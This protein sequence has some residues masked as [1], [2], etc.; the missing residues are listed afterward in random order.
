MRAVFFFL[1]GQF[2]QW[3][4]RRVCIERR[5]T[6][7]ESGR[8]QRKSASPTSVAS[9]SS[10]LHLP[11]RSKLSSSSTFRRGVAGKAAG[12][13]FAKRS[14]PS[15]APSGQGAATR[16]SASSDD[17]P[18]VGNCKNQRPTKRPRYLEGG[19]ADTSE[20]E[21]AAAVV[22]PAAFAP[23]AALVKVGDDGG[24][25]RL[26][27]GWDV[28]SDMDV[29]ALLGMLYD[30]KAFGPILKGVAL[31]WC[32]VRVLKGCLPPGKVVPDAA[33]EA[34][35]NTV[36]LEGSK[37]ISRAAQEAGCT[38]EVLWVRVTLPAEKREL[39]AAVV[40]R[41]CTLVI[42]LFYRLLESLRVVSSAS[43]VLLPTLPVLSH[44]TLVAAELVEQPPR[45]PLARLAAALPHATLDPSDKAITLPEGASWP[46]MAS[47][48]LYV[49]HFYKGLWEGVLNSGR[50]AEGGLTGAALMG[51]P[52]SEY[53]APQASG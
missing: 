23:R 18:E 2:A 51:T 20:E 26:G 10:V 27:V 35:D 43:P 30:T 31:S 47:P 50:A 29:T 52:G 6:H 3:L 40:C 44:P 41:H 36:R 13:M 22:V 19:P 39:S 28:L 16:D 11:T 48:V 25:S 12:T 5:R 24:Y 42:S 15:A 45:S 4:G 21:A 14:R 38:G 37:T 33:D 49:R 53:A 34:P 1:N 7:E 32:D 9:A 8:K 46:G 17:I